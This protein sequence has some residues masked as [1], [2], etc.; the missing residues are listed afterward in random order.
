S[1]GIGPNLR[2]DPL[3]RLHAT[4]RTQQLGGHFFLFRA[5]EPAP[6]VSQTRNNVVVCIETLVN[7]RSI[8]GHIGM[9]LMHVSNALWR[10][11]QADKFE[12][13]RARILESMQGCNR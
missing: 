12:R 10:R 4:P 13:F 1:K 8:D 9:L 2:K 5:K 3:W 6:R 11:Q 7:R